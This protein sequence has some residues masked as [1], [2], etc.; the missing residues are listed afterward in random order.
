MD[1]KWKPTFVCIFL[2]AA[3]VLSCHAQNPCQQNP[4]QNGGSCRH[5]IL[6][7]YYV[8]LCVNDY[9]G[10]DCQ[11]RFG[12]K[13]CGANSYT[14][15]G[16]ITSPNFPNSYGFNEKC[17]Y[18]VRVPE[19]ETIT[20]VFTQ[21]DT[22]EFK[23]DLYIAEGP[24]FYENSWDIDTY[25]LPNGYTRYHGG[26]LNVA[27]V[28]YQTNQ[29]TLYWETDRNI[30]EPGFHIYYTRET[31]PCWQ[32]QCQ[33]GGECQAVD[34][35]EY[36][37]RCPVGWSGRLCNSGAILVRQTAISLIS[38]NPLFEGRNRHGFEFNL[39]VYPGNSANYNIIGTNLWQVNLFLSNQ[40]DGQGER[41]SE[42]T[43]Q[44]SSEQMSASWIPP[45]TMNIGNIQTFLDLNQ[46]TCQGQ[47]FVC[48]S[49]DRGVNPSVNFYMQGTPTNTS[50]VGC[51]QVSCTG[52][53]IVT[54]QLVWKTQNALREGFES[55]NV[56]FDIRM[57]PDQQS[58]SVSGSALWVVKLYGNTLPDGSGTR[59]QEQTLVLTP[60]N[61]QRA[62]TPGLQTTLSDITTIRNM[63]GL[64]CAETPSVNI[65]DT[66]LEIET[67][68][69]LVER[70]VRHSLR[71]DLLIEPDPTGG[72]AI[73]TELWGHTCESNCQCLSY[74][75]SKWN[76]SAP[77]TTARIQNMEANL[78]LQGVLCNQ[79]VTVCAVLSKNPL[80]SPSYTFETD[81]NDPALTACTNVNCRGVTITNLN[82]GLLTGSQFQYGD[83]NHDFSI[84]FTGLVDSTGASITGSGLWEMSAYLGTDP[85]GNGQRLVETQ[86][87]LTPAQQ[88]MAATAG[89]TL[90]FGSL[91]GNMDLSRITGC[92]QFSYFCVDLRKADAPNPDFTLSEPVRHC[93]R[94]SCDVFN[95]CVS[96]PCFN[97]G[98]CTGS[99]G[100]YVCTCP[101]QYTG[102]RCNIEID[103]CQTSN[104]VCQ[105]GGTCLNQGGTFFCQCR[106]GWKGTFCGNVDLGVQLSSTELSISFGTLVERQVT[107]RPLSLNVGIQSLP[108]SQSIAGTGLW[109]LE[110][111]SNTQPDGSGQ[112]I[113]QQM[114]TLD[115]RN[116]NIGLLAGGTA[117]FSDVP[118][119]IDL[120]GY[121]CDSVPYLCIRVLK[122]DNPSP[123]FV[124]TGNN[125][126][127]VESQ[128][129]GVE[130]TRVG[131]TINSGRELLIGEAA[132]SVNFDLTA[133][134][135]SAGASIIGNDLWRVVLFTNTQI[136]GKGQIGAQ[137]DAIL[138]N[139]DEDRALIAGQQLLITNAQAQLNLQQLT[140]EQSDSENPDIKVTHLCVRLER[141]PAATPAFTL[142][143]L[144]ND[145]LTYC[146]R[147]SCQTP[148]PCANNQC[149]NG[150]ICRE[151]D[152]NFFFCECPA[153]WIGQ[154]CETRVNFCANIQCLNGGTCSNL[155]T[156]YQCRCV[157]GWTGI[158]CE[159]QDAVIITSLQAI[160][161]GYF[162]EGKSSNPLGFD[163]SFT[164]D[165]T[166]SGIQGSGL[167]RLVVYSN[168][169]AD[170]SGT[171]SILRVIEFDQPLQDSTALPAGGSAFLNGLSADFD[172]TGLTCSQ[173]PY[174][175]IELQKGDSPNPDFVLTGQT[176][177]CVPIECR[178][179]QITNT[180]ISVTSAAT[181]L[182]ERE[183]GNGVNFDLT[184]TSSSNGGSI[185]GTNLW[186]V[187]AFLN[188]Q[189]DGSGPEISQTS[190]YLNAQQASTSLQAGATATIPGI[191]A[192][193][194]LSN[195]RCSDDIRY[196]CTRV[197]RS[198]S[199]SVAFTMEPPTRTSC[200]RIECK[201]VEITNVEAGIN[202]GI[203][204]MAGASD[205]AIN[206]YLSA[207]S[208]P[209]GSSV[210]GTNLWQVDV[211]TNTQRD[212]SGYGMPNRKPHSHQDLE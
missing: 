81:S 143:G 51:Q 98:T 52:V 29:L 132:H 173:L 134:A 113:I 70:S 178:G 207:S 212:G 103:F 172:L 204:I 30:N 16:N 184:L 25:D 115:P 119:S 14:E 67:G 192:T 181:P 96:N 17:L 95:P 105:N 83:P 183:S 23:D 179:V 174:I 78:D 35:E 190:V 168:T 123:D 167:W 194:D 63:L 22:E 182:K 130:V 32:H 206:F 76:N 186:D 20:F 45:N 79:L 65:I 112:T 6:A 44:L 88:A 72:A 11:T 171:S 164:S 82:V 46:V 203:P 161:Q 1:V 4:C 114:L 53:R 128:C 201:G 104:I 38:G 75:E 170:G 13:N 26:P 59:V 85:D 18:L 89:A 91:A 36:Q 152:S 92:T 41:I 49:I 199:A 208:N 21:F 163:V 5:A 73:G 118:A 34:G 195:R 74:S 12:E 191:T 153:L 160:A 196:F 56:Q 158:R 144:P 97:G 140:C 151:I 180:A 169:Q 120:S 99:D 100:S 156:T 188:S 198:T 64:A 50:L 58:G 148:S 159:I 147:V 185:E 108:T 24:T 66:S 136:D 111:F 33:N 19:A 71:Y 31:D 155:A 124:L 7:P 137:S 175:C 189:S 202:S 150:G 101:Q 135:N 129:K 138:V 80:A 126:D 193:L 131:Y 40:Q 42:T 2:L 125:V 177:R 107:S 62:V 93:I 109:K 28:T 211:F 116:A 3:L 43:T 9:M 110:V 54:T 127:C 141:D 200:S 154:Y 15:S 86:F 117:G 162:G 37:C 47:K 121:T 205:Q 166:G 8:C 39:A 122:G 209:F 69:P 210:S 139:G 48:A 145:V 68:N 87:N 187:T 94:A 60:P 176:R 90:T 61:S 102:P 106:L 84:F 10:Q 165:P 157:T 146:E 57:M 149:Q 55:Q 197:Q 133:I 142:T 27:P 77:P